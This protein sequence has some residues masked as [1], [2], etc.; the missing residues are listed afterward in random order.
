[1]QD[2]HFITPKARKIENTKAGDTLLYAFEGRYIEYKVL[3]V[4]PYFV[5]A[6]DENGKRRSFNVGD[7]VKMGKEP[8]NGMFIETHESSYNDYD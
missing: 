7:L 2:N 5:I 8:S 4:Y 3:E 1:M 6:E